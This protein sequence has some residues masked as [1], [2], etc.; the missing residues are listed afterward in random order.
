MAKGIIRLAKDIIIREEKEIIIRRVTVDRSHTPQQV[1]DA[2]GRKQ[3]TDSEVVMDMPHGEGAE[4][5]VVFFWVC[6]SWSDP[7]LD[8]ECAHH[9]LIPADPYSIAAVNKA[10]PAFAD[11]HPNSG[12]WKDANGR[13]CYMAFNH[14]RG[15]RNVIVKRGGSEWLVERWF[16]GLRKTT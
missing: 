11:T 6:R 1:L 13:W 12:H 7:D 2:M 10:D 8:Q 3:D 9:G 5:D 15:K 4:V 16:A 14:W